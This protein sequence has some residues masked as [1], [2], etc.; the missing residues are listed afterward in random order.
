M[1]TLIAALVLS[2]LTA[3]VMALTL[4]SDAMTGAS[5]TDV[6]AP[7]GDAFGRRSGACPQRPDQPLLQGGAVARERSTNTCGGV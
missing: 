6:L 2:T 5:A 4:P 1:K 7:S 3:P